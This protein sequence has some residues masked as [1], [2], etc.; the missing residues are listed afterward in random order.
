[1]SSQSACVCSKEAVHLQAQS[2]AC[3]NSSSS[4]DSHLGSAAG[5]N[6]LMEMHEEQIDSQNS[7]VLSTTIGSL[8]NMTI[9]DS[10]EGTVDQKNEMSVNLT[11]QI[12][13]LEVQLKEQREWAQKKAIQAARKLSNDLM[14]LKLLRMER[15][16]TLRMKKGKQTLEDTTMKRLS[17]M[18]NAL[19]KASGQVN[20]ANEDVRRLETENA[21][22]RA[23]MEASKLSSSESLETC[24][25]FAKK[26]KK[27]LKKCMTLEKQKDKLQEEIV[28]EKK[29]ISLLKEQLQLV[30]ESQKDAE[31]RWKQEL[32]AKELVI[33]QLEEEQRSKE[34]SNSKTRQH[35]LH[36]KIEI[37][38]QRYK[39]DIQRLE[40]ELSRL[41]ASAEASQPKCPINAFVKGEP[42]T[43][44]TLREANLRMPHNT[45]KLQ[46]PSQKEVGRNKKKCVICMLDEVCVVFL[47]CAHEVLCVGCNGDHER[48]AKTKCPC[49]GVQIEERIHVYGATS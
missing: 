43:S 20:R 24:L 19:R 46:E 16:E 44:K 40:L 30:R 29:K 28:E 2:C 17:E 25:K 36:H 39:D 6:E 9:D 10:S 32:N 12:S 11:R 42:D 8:G 27:C 13:E 31:I 22:I 15:E 41:K 45:Q 48:E 5:Y 1:M 26:E 3:L 35:A 33:S 4:N 18:E 14:E 49:C 23:E 47:P 7:D 34:A 37:D 38:Y 21:E